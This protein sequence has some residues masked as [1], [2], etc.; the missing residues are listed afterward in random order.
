[1][2]V[3]GRDRWPTPAAALRCPSGAC[4]PWACGLWPVACGPGALSCRASAAQAARN[5]IIAR[6]PYE[7][8][9]LHYSPP[10]TMAAKRQ[11]DDA[12]AQTPAKRQRSH[13]D[14]KKGFSVGPANL[15]DGTYKRKGELHALPDPAAAV[16]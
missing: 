7:R 3:D 16:C 14:R 9:T 15:P 4:L 5:F 6:Q 11:R 12:D 8:N 13:A 2:G 1:M 10:R